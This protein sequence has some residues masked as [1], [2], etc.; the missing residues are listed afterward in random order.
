MK[1]TMARFP[2]VSATTSSLSYRIFFRAIAERLKSHTGDLYALNVG[3]TW[4]EPLPRAQAEAQRTDAHPHLHRY[5]PVQGEPA[6]LDAIIARVQRRTGV[7][8]ERGAVQVVSGA[9][10]GLSV[11]VQTLLDPGDEVLLPAPYWPLIRGVIA[12]RGATPI[13]LPMLETLAEAHR[14]DACFDLEAVFEAAVTPRTAAI[15]LNSPN[16]PTGVILTD[17]ELAAVGRVAE[18]HDLWI[19]CDEVYEDLWL[20]TPEHGPE[21]VNA[22]RPAWLHPSITERAIVVHSLS[23]AYGL[24]GARIGYLHGPPDVVEEIR[25]VQAFQVYCAAKPMSLGAANALNEGDS[26]LETTRRYYSEAA[27]TASKILGLPCPPG[28][29]FLFFDATPYVAPG[30][31]ATPFLLKCVDAGVALTPGIASGDAYAN[32]VRLCFSSLPPAELEEALHRVRGVMDAC[33][34]EHGTGAADAHSNV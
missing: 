13:Q 22:P 25:S 4:R 30:E 11:V 15:Y 2:N 12:S 8:L 32:W 28:G 21:E 29:T 26:W 18:R 6:L 10:S 31:D 16:N 5:A 9:T 20:A 17:A 27:V 7:T 14:A 24:A 1:T 33:I 19:L 34:A 3:D 23:K